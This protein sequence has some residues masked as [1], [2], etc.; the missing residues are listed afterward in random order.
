MG[1]YGRNF[2]FRIVPESENR[3]ARFSTPA[4]GTFVM[5]QPVQADDTAGVDTL[6]RQVIKAGVTATA[7]TKGRCGIA[8]YEHGDGATWAGVDPYLTTY[9]DLGTLPNSKAVQMVSGP[10]VKVVLRNT[11]ASTF[12]QNRAYAARNMIAENGA[13]PNV[14]IGSYLEPAT[15]PNDTN[16]YWQTTLTKA[17]AW[18]VVVG[19]DATRQEVE[20]NFLF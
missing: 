9:S 12:L 18:L 19:V 14:I 17:N 6:G 20:A 10:N 5:G 4:T 16:G 3:L 2:E 8:I 13:T 7:P 11:D 1:S 15:T